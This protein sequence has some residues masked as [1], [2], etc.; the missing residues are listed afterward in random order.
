MAQ[1]EQILRIEVTAEFLG[2]VRGVLRAGVEREQC[3]EIR[4]DGR[5][6][7][8]PSLGV[9]Q[10]VQA[11]EC[12]CGEQHVGAVLREL[13]E[14]LLVISAWECVEFVHDQGYGSSVVRRLDGL[15]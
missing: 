11:C 10:S 9:D 3:V 13:A 2:Q 6:E 5:P 4:K 14:E 8:T 12:L 1:L 15:R 7:V